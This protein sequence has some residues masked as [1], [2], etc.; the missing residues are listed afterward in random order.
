MVDVL[1]SQPY[2][3]LSTVPQILLTAFTWWYSVSLAMTGVRE[4]GR[5][6]FLMLTIGTSFGRGVM[7]AER[8]R[9]GMNDS[10]N[11]LFCTAHRGP[12]MI[13]ANSRRTQFGMQS[14]PIALQVFTC[15]SCLSVSSTGMMNS[16]GTGGYSAGEWESAGRG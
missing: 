13:S 7:L 8:H 9:R 4:I 5:T 1:S 6:S 10:L 3:D 2:C 11:E 14:G 15:V 12:A 16:S